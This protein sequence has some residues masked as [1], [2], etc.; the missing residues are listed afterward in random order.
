VAA[1]ASA[2]GLVALVVRIDADPV[3]ARRGGFPH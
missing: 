3:R 1:D 2:D